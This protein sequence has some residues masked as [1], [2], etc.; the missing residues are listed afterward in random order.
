[1]I[2]LYASPLFVP[3]SHLLFLPLSHPDP[4]PLLSASTSPHADWTQPPDYLIDLSLSIISPNPKP[5][6]RPT[7]PPKRP[8]RRLCRR[9]PWSTSR[10]STG[11]RGL[12][13]VGLDWIGLD[14]VCDGREA[15]DQGKEMGMCIIYT[16]SNWKRNGMKFVRMSWMSWVRRS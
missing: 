7:P 6:S 9:I 11:T 15:V 1:M 13:H 16:N 4:L 8:T 14:G 2:R 12:G 5:S 3:T 10:R